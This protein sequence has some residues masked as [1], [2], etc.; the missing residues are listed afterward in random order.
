MI[1]AFAGATA[2]ELW[3]E[4]V[5]GFADEHA[6]DI[7]QGRGGE[8]KEMLH[9]SLTLD[10]PQQ[11][12]VLSRRPALNVAFAIAEV[13]W[14]VSGRN[15]SDFLTYW[16]RRLPEFV[17]NGPTLHGAYGHRLRHHFQIDQ[18]ERAY[19]ALYRNPDSRQV[20]LQIWDSEVD[21]PALDGSPSDPDVPCNV[22]S[23]VKARRGKL[24]W[25]QVMRS[26]DV[27]LGLPHNIVQFTCLQEILAG[28][29][30]MEVG[31]YNQLSDSL[32]IYQRDLHN[33]FSRTPAADIRNDDSLML[34]KQESQK[35]F[36]ELEKRTGTAMLH[37]LK[38]RQLIQLLTWQYGPPSL[39]N[40]L[41]IL[42]A[43]SARRRGWHDAQTLAE[44]SCGNPAFLTLWHSWYRRVTGA[45]ETA[46]DGAQE[47]LGL[48]ESTRLV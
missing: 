6:S 42:L 40:M 13:I 19:S 37:D 14:I 21:F 12:W 32:H 16:N 34:P 44:E 5:D 36:A 45:N 46:V 41:S 47:N 28:W 23:L 29:L 24:E 11:R 1:Q 3:R 10:N 20:V 35:A 22:L 9:V 27:F 33:V 2:D 7:H 38:E 26:N 25:M 43:E 8:T 31:S 15:D 39:K 4:V 48:A 18:L 30:G 17:G